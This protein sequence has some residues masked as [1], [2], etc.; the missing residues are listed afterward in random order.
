MQGRI[1]CRGILKD[2]AT[3]RYMSIAA[4][5]GC[6]A[7]EM[8]GYFGTPAELHHPR[9]KA[10]IGERGSDMEVIPLCPSHHRGLGDR[11]YPTG[12]EFPSIHMQ[13]GWFRWKYGEDAELSEL[14]RKRVC[15]LEHRTIGKRPL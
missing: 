8:D 4:T 2:A 9:A 6:I 15:E 12:E 11:V 10:G 3:S 1:F 7:C 5:L 14:V 13:T